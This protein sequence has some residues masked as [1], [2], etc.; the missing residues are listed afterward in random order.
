MGPIDLDRVLPLV[1]RPSRYLGSEVNSVHKDPS[2][3][4]VRAVLAFPDLYEV[5]MSH[6]G[7]GILYGLGNQLERVQVERCF[8]P[9]ED[10]LEVLKAR[11]LP[12][13]SLESRTP[14]VHCDL[15]GVTLQSELT[16]TNVLTVLDTGGIP[17]HARHRKEGH[18]LVLG[19]GPCAFNPE[20]LHAF[21][22]LVFLGD[23][24]AGWP[25]LLLAARA[26]KEGGGDRAAVKEALKAVPGVYD[27]SDFEIDYGDDGRVTGIRGRGDVDTV[28]RASVLDIGID[29]PPSSFLVPFSQP[30]HDRLALEA[31]RGCTRGCRFCH[32]GM[33]YRPVRERSMEDL[34]RMADQGLQRTGYEDLS[35][36]SLSM[37][38]LSCL[39]DL[40]SGVMDR[41]QEDRISVSLPSMRVGG[42]TP[43]VARQIRRVKK[44]GF[45]IAPEAGTRRLRKV[46]N[47]DFSDDE[48]V[49]TVEWV[50]RMGWDTVKLYFMIGLPT[51]TE[52]DLDG[53]VDLVEA[54]AERAP[55]RGKVT[56]NIS[57][58]VP[59]PHTP[60]QWVAQDA[61]EVLRSKLD[62]L[63]RKLKG[64]KVQVRWGRTDQA[65]LEAV[66]ARG[67]RRL[68]AVVESAW[69]GGA[70]M[71]G[72]DE[73]FR[74][75][76]WAAALASAGLDPG[77]Y[78]SRTRDRDEVFPWDHLSCGVS[79]DYLAV[80]YE[81][82]LRGEAVPDCRESGCRGCGACTGDQADHLPALR[83]PEAADEDAGTGPGGEPAGPAMEQD[84]SVRRIRIVFSKTGDM[85]YLGHL[86]TTRAF[87]RAARRGKVPLAFSGGYSPKPRITFALAL[88]LGVEG[89]RDWADLE[90]VES[91][92][93]GTVLKA[94]NPQLPAGLEILEA[95]KAPLEGQALNVR[96]RSMVYT[97]L[98]PRPVEDLSRRVRSMVMSKEVT[99][100]RKRKGKTRT[101]NLKDYLLDLEALENT[102]VRFALTLK[103][104]GGKWTVADHEIKDTYVGMFRESHARE[105]ACIPQ[106]IQYNLEMQVRYQLPCNR[107]IVLQNIKPRKI[108]FFL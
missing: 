71:D 59:K 22:D 58:Y 25:G 91:W 23:G 49:S 10:M 45:T 97:A 83:E 70:R 21:F 51:E 98:F 16:Y 7:T 52:E 40:L 2:D 13:F 63:R 69:R 101:L 100:T 27:P 67:D 8:L 85:K 79:R 81:R 28:A 14:L 56:V 66:L 84:R 44:T 6:Q 47:K 65:L 18:P 3:I 53:L 55:S 61:E 46:V 33:V 89:E 34:L 5:G 103:K 90:L 107:I 9:Q 50:F 30:V 80:E 19:G 54:V 74:W 35:F 29:L 26:T 31:A 92:S 37:G 1:E 43:E 24:E 78:A 88:P 39:N 57:P 94:L 93:P 105:I 42:L 48:I 108:I 36:T 64:K 104:D 4:S 15:I 86:E 106:Q 38:D 60:F 72:W 95:W 62:M 12:L 96:V 20:P 11:D 82:G 76:V 73:H 99:L 32:A 41:Y 17:L 87:E 68:S 77:L 75:D 102:G